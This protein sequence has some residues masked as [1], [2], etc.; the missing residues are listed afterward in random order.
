MSRS[1]SATRS[2]STSAI[3]GARGVV[4]TGLSRAAALAA[5]D[6][7]DPEGLDASWRELDQAVAAN[8][9]ETIRRGRDALDRVEKALLVKAIPAPAAD[10][11]ARLVARQEVELRVESAPPALRGSVTL[12]LA[13]SGDPAIRAELASSWGRAFVEKVGGIDHT[14]LVARAVKAEADA[15]SKAAAA[16]LAA[17]ELGIRL[18][19]AEEAT[20]HLGRAMKPGRAAYRQ[21]S[22]RENR[23]ADL[24]DL[25][26]VSGGDAA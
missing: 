11:S 10:A 19:R 1:A 24:A 18:V 16:F 13:S 23:H 17:G 21:P 5:N 20:H 8:A 2:T 4:E 25:A 9:G 14:E 26:G 3:A 6:E 12:E 7:G 22:N 15:G